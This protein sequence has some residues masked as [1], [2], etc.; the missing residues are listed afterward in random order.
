MGSITFVDYP[1][2]SYTVFVDN[3]HI[4]TVHVVSF[5]GEDDQLDHGH[6]VVYVDANGQVQRIFTHNGIV[7]NYKKA[8]S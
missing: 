1:N 5:I 2:G 7:L 3:I 4:A 6:D 8:L